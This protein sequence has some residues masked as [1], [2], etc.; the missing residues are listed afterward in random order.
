MSSVFLNDSSANQLVLEAYDSG[1]RTY[2]VQGTKFF[3]KRSPER[4]D[5]IFSVTAADGAINAVA[6]G[7]A[8]PAV[9]VEELG[10]VT[11]TQQ[12]YK[13]EIPVDFLMKR[14]D[15]YGVVIR[16]ATKHGY[17]AKQVM[18]Q[19]MADVL[20]N[21]EGTTTTWDALSLANAAHLIGNTGTTQSNVVTGA[22]SETTL[23]AAYV[24]LVNQQDHGGQ[25]MPTV[26]MYL[27]VPPALHIT[28]HKLLNSNQGPETANRETG[29]LNGLGM[30]TVVW[31]LLD[32]AVDWWLLADK[33]YNRL[34][35]LVSVEPTVIYREDSDTGNGLYQIEFACAAG[36]TD[37]LG[38]IFGNQA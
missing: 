32:D 18:D 13:K 16:E 6:P 14:F 10:S 19:V 3:N 24:A 25:V 4:F 9:N 29:F 21:G 8:Y 1:W 26:G 17:R 37:Y 30:Q 2:E 11:I 7:A 34:E 28:S 5:E 20:N 33:M 36:A 15:N 38:S 23:N 27:V 22:L 31:P 35:Y 12:A